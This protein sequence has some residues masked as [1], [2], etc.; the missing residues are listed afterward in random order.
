MPRENAL[1]KCLACGAA[2]FGHVCAAMTAEW[3]QWGTRVPLTV[4]WVD[5]CTVTQARSLP[6]PAAVRIFLPTPPCAREPR[7]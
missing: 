2:I 7:A 1:V 4:L 5:N 6:S 3:D